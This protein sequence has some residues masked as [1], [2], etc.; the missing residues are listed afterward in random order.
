[1]DKCSRGEKYY[2]THNQ[3]LLFLFCS[4][5]ICGQCNP[6]IGI[7]QCNVLAQTYALNAD[8]GA[9][10]GTPALALTL[11]DWHCLKHR[12]GGARAVPSLRQTSPAGARRSRWG[13]AF[14]S[15]GGRQACWPGEGVGPGFDHSAKSK[16][17]TAF[18]D[19]HLLCALAL[20]RV[21]FSSILC[22]IQ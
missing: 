8:A 14:L 17:R 21:R 19:P 12:P 3:Y 7:A 15:G 5:F 22:W 6:G 9:P 18:S 20:G 13:W 4:C 2:V 11:L 10:N 1:M 16:G